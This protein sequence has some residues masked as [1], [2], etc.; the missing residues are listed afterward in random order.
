MN[1][2]EVTRGSVENL[3]VPKPAS[4][5]TM[6]SSSESKLT[7]CQ[8]P[9]CP[10]SSCWI[11]SI[12]QNLWQWVVSLFCP[13][14]EITPPSQVRQVVAL[15]Q[16]FN[17]EEVE[18]EFYEKHGLVTEPS[19]PIKVNI[20]SFEGK[21]GIKLDAVATQECYSRTPSPTVSLSPYVDQLDATDFDWDADHTLTFREGL[22]F[23]VSYINH[24]I[25]KN[26]M[27]SSKTTTSQI[28]RIN[29][30]RHPIYRVLSLMQFSNKEA[31]PHIIKS[32]RHY[33]TWFDVACTL[34]E[35][36]GHILAFHDLTGLGLIQA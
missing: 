24:Q 33:I 18:K 22:Q 29:L 28:R 14:E 1:L 30:D 34:L 35:E 4:F 21:Y 8:G 36:E 31:V 19:R 7:S 2:N 27:N 9:A 26:S 32:S 12:F 3:G 6:A 17:F 10:I 16:A 13:P 23:L 25:E 15:N 11:V 20:A 5:Q